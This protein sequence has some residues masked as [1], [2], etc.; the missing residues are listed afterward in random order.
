MAAPKGTCNRF[1]R[2]HR[3]V[4][5]CQDWTPAQTSKAERGYAKQDWTPYTT[6][7]DASTAKELG[8]TV[9][10]LR[11]DRREDDTQ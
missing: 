8:I 1:S 11:Q 9:K 5:A 7:E 4:K 2:P 3:K 6:P 10:Q